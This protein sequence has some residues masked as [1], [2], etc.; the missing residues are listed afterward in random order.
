MRVAVLD[1]YQN[2]ATLM[3]D[4]TQLPGDVTVTCFT[5]HEPDPVKLGERLKGYEIVCIMRER[6]PFTRATFENLPDM[7]LLIT[8]GMRNASV[9]MQAAADH[10]VTVC[11]T[12]G[13]GHPT[14]ELAFGLMLSLA[15][16][17]PNENNA[18]R[19]GRWQTQIGMGMKGRT[20][21]LLGL[22]N[23]GTKVAK[24]AQAFEMD[25]IAWSQNLTAEAAAEK[26]VRRVEKDELFQQSDFISVHLVLSD[27]SRGIVG[28]RELELMKSTAYIVNT[29][30][31]PIIDEEALAEALRNET[32]G[33]A[34]IDTY[35]LEPVPKTNPFLDLRNTVLTPHL[36]YVTSDTY[37]LFYG[38]TV[39]NI[40]AWLKGEPT[41]VIS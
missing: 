26:G 18:M 25:T 33:G 7:K 1:D 6:T 19:Q 15:R 10:A 34:G 5:D 27:R 35:G 29:S 37:E 39:E 21:G 30:R 36:G 38:Q 41:R 12:Q 40:S 3:A 8:T 28:K 2:V 11:G 31:G 16:N 4:W 24:Y 17:I 14:P 23:L 22:G 13:S 9:D 32:I 20:C